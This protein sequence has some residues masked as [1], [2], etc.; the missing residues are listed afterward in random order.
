MCIMSKKY[1]YWFFYIDDKYL[2][3]IYIEEPGSNLYAYTDNYDIAIK[4]KT[5]SS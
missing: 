5:L 3:I 4:F 1:K 2:D